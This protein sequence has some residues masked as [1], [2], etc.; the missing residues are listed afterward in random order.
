MSIGQSL[1][2]ARVRAG[3]TVDRLSEVT[4]IR[5]AVIEGIEQDDFEPCGGDFYARGHIRTVARA[6]GVDPMPLLAEYDATVGGRSTPRPIEIFDSPRKSI[7]H[8][9]PN[10]SM[11]MGVAVVIVLIFAFVQLAGGRADEDEKATASRVTPTT[12]LQPTTPAAPAPPPPPVESAVQS[13]QFPAEVTVLVNAID[14][15]SWVRTLDAEGK[16]IFETILAKG[17]SKTFS[18]PAK[19]E[20]QIGNSGAVQLTVNGKEVGAAG[21][22]GAVVKYTFVP[23]DPAPQMQSASPTPSTK[24]PSTSPTPSAGRTTASST[25]STRRTSASPTPSTGR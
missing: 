10:W 17:E 5:Q 2:E 9:R 21:P 7:E 22:P 4:R 11:A 20:L 24:Q 6:T 19:L 8:R 12:T 14:G 18:D 1:S 25:P 23:G 3:L 13:P 16:E 15:P